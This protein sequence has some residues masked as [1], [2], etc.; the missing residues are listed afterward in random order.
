VKTQKAQATTTNQYTPR[1]QKPTHRGENIA[2]TKI[3]LEIEEI[4]PEGGKVEMKLVQTGYAG[5]VNNLYTGQMN[6]Q[7][8]L[9][10]FIVF[11]CQM[12]RN[13]L[14][15][16]TSHKHKILNIHLCG[17]EFEEILFWFLCRFL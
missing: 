16:E 2:F 15:F 4:L 11:Y 8:K 7:I 14:V 3:S 17:T 1:N 12:L 13:V 6:V 9:C 5:G 10:C